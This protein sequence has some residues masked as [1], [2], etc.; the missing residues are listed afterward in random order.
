MRKKKYMYAVFRN[1]K[2]TKRFSDLLRSRS[3]ELMNAFLF[4]E[5]VENCGSTDF[6]KTVTKSLQQLKK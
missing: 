6:K 5:L 4:H 2:Q 1:N 3:V